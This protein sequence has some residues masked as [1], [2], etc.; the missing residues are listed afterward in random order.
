MI[1]DTERRSCKD[2]NCLCKLSSWGAWSACCHDGGGTKSNSTTRKR[3]ILTNYEPCDNTERLEQSRYC[4]KCP[5]INGTEFTCY[6]SE[7]RCISKSW[8]CDGNKDCRNGEDELNC[9]KSN[10]FTCQ[11]GFKCIEK[12][13]LCDEKKD[14][15]GGE[16]ERGCC[17]SKGKFTCNNYKCISKSWICDG[18]NDCGGGED[19]LPFYCSHRVFA[20]SKS[21]KI[22]STNFVKLLAFVMMVALS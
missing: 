18:Y 4:H 16:D 1:A 17:E 21:R 9:C 6:K 19:E 7:N 5:C 22:S 15:D 3:H 20:N 14:C 12:S 10:Q 2:R 8:I 11:D 13:Q